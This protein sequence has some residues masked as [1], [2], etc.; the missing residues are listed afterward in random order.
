MPAPEVAEIFTTIVEGIDGVEEGVLVPAD[1]ALTAVE[2]IIDYQAMNTELRNLETELD[3][4]NDKLAWITPASIAL[5]ALSTAC[6]AATIAV[7]N[8]IIQMGGTPPPQDEDRA[9]SRYDVSAA[10]AA[11]AKQ[12]SKARIACD[13]GTAEGISNAIGVV[14]QAIPES[15]INQLEGNLETLDASLDKID[16]AV[17][18]IAQVLDPI[19]GIKGTLDSIDNTLHQ[20]QTDLDKFDKE[21]YDKKISV[22]NLSPHDIVKDM[23]NAIKTVERWLPFVGDAKKWIQNELD[24]LM[25]AAADQMKKEVEKM[26]KSIPGMP[27]KSQIDE[28][29]DKFATIEKDIDGLEPTTFDPQLFNTLDSAITNLPSC[30]SL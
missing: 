21:I 2:D 26:V 22:I 17:G 7:K 5:T 3:T 1:D 14:R 13:Y 29:K 15:N 8:D 27:T 11:M 12:I 9:V 20:I 10:R 18:E 4:A 19:A 23:A 16:G 25:K 28:L 30:A 24:S 6:T